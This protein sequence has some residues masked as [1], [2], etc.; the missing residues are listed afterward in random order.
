MVRRALRIREGDVR[1]EAVGW[2]LETRGASYA[3]PALSYW[4][5]VN[6]D[7]MGLSGVN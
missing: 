6:G 4:W 2:V 7:A 5:C 3:V 1:G